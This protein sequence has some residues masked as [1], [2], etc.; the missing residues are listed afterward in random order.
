MHWKAIHLFSHS[1][2]FSIKYGANVILV[3]KL[4]EVSEVLH[5]SRDFLS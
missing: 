4:I 3:V 1:F 5:H 2:E